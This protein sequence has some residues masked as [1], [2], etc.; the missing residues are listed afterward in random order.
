M[1]ATVLLSKVLGLCIIV[2]GAAIIL[3][4]HYFLP[5]FLYVEQLSLKLGN[6]EQV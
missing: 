5:V 4:R 1:E 6:A 2:I 3:R